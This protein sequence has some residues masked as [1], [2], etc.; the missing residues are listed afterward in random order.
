MRI[1]MNDKYEELLMG[2]QLTLSEITI[3][4]LKLD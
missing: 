1:N 2:Y 4:E 3:K